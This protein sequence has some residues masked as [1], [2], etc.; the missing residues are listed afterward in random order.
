[1]APRQKREREKMIPP[2]QG[3]TPGETIIDF[4]LMVTQKNPFESTVKWVDSFNNSQIPVHNNHALSYI[5]HEYGRLTTLHG[6][7]GQNINNARLLIYEVSCAWSK[8]YETMN[9]ARFVDTRY[10][11]EAA[12][13]RFV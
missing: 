12:I 6:M 2:Y 9:Q 4:I 1:M 10:S 8:P 7:A 5:F 13:K 11:N 3:Y